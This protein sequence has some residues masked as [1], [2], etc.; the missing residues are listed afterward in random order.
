MEREETGKVL[1]KSELDDRIFEAITESFKRSYVCIKNVD[2]GVSRWSL[3]AV[4]DLGLSGEYMENAFEAIFERIHP[5]ERDSYIEYMQMLYLEQ[6]EGHTKDYRIKKVDGKYARCTLYGRVIPGDEQ[7]A[8]LFVSTIENHSV[9]DNIDPV[10]DLYNI[11]EFW[12]VV[13]KSKNENKE[14]AILLLCINNF[15]EINDVYGYDF[16]NSVLREFA[17]KLKKIINGR[18]PVFRMDG[19]QFACCFESNNTKE[20]SEIYAE[21]QHQARHDIYVNNV[22]I[23]VSISG[24]VAVD[25]DAYDEYSIQISTRYA[26]EKSKHKCHGEL[27]FFDAKTLTEMKSNLFLMKTIRDTIIDGCD[28]F[29][30]VYQ[31]IVDANSEKVLGAETLLRWNEEP[32]GEVSPAQFIPW[33]ENDP[34]FWELGKWILRT[35]FTDAKTFLEQQPDFMLSVNV[36][37]PQLSRNDFLDAIELILE[38]TGFPAQNLCLELTERCRQ[39]D[40]EHLRYTIDHLKEMGIRIS[41]DDFG[42][43]YSSLS[44]LG[45][46][47]VDTLKIDGGFVRDIKVNYA[48]QS[49]IKAITSCA[50][51]MKVRVCVEGIEDRDTIDFIK[52]YPVHSFQG[53]YFSRPIPK[54]VFL[55]E[56]YN[57]EV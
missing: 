27:M 45:D 24:G 30:L 15:S 57:V 11:Y 13:K 51:D 46:L 1:D 25:N 37:Y 56:Y 17:K 38:E 16:G 2:T 43:G 9:M 48:N 19:V 50:Q 42:T 52:Q 29:Y 36:A 49:I 40:K 33:L 6:N 21:L 7:H 47:S 41:I 14:L 20:I 3:N 5:Q 18:S 12:N 22:R 55:Q 39:L 28:G 4:E 44:L 35:S 32:F 54:K 26:L 23:A 10:T 31:P 8:P 53:Y 34:R